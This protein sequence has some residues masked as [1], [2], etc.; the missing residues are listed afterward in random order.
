MIIVTGAN[1]QLGR[2]IVEELVHLVPAGQLVASVRDPE[3][4]AALQALGVEVRRGDFAEPESLARV[5]AGAT[6]VLLVSSNAAAYGGDPLAQHRAA[7]DAARA[8]GAK[9]IVYTSHMATSAASLFPPMRDHAKTEAML[10]E[11]GLA[12]TS[13]RHG[14]YAASGLMLM[15]NALKTGVIEAPADGKVAWTAHADLAA[16]DAAILADIFKGN[17]ARYD[18]PTPPLT[19]SAALDLADLAALA[20]DLLGRPVR[21]EVIAD[22]ELQARLASRGL[23]EG[24]QALTLGLYAASRK[25]EF[26]ALDPMLAGLIGRPPIAMRD[27]IAQAIAAQAA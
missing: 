23:P 15:G 5:F 25:G 11:S 27:I 13:L 12:W 20:S 18:G 22:T 1:G 26:S 3:K 21:R 2:A 7:I 16:A 8:A 9:R 14:F 4:A 6:A 19:G 10:A 24:A 17:G